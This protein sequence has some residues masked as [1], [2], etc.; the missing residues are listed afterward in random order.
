MNDPRRRRLSSPAKALLLTVA[1]VAGCVGADDPL[2]TSSGAVV[3]PMTFTPNADARVEQ[4]YGGSTF[5]TSSRLIVDGSPRTESYLRFQVSG[6]GW[7]VQRATLRLYAFDG[8]SSGPDVF[9][10]TSFWDENTLT[11]NNRPSPVGASVGRFR[12]VSK[13]NWVELDV[14]TAVTKEGVISFVL[15]PNSSDGMDFYSREGSR[16]PELIVVPMDPPTTPVDAGT[17]EDAGTA[18]DAGVLD[19]GTNADAGVTD[20]GSNADAGTQP[21]GTTFYVDATLGNDSNTGTSPSQAWRTTYRATQASLAPGDALRLARGGVYSGALKMAESGT[22]SKPILVA[23]YGSGAPPIITG[24]SSCLVV[25]GSYIVVEGVHAKD[26]TWA[27]VDLAGSHNRIEDL[28]ITG[29]AAGVH[30]RSGAIGNRILRSRLIDNNRMSVLTSGGDDDSGAFGLVIQGDHTEVAF[31]TIRGC[32]AFS[33]DYGRDGAAVE[34]YG[35]QNNHIHHN[36]AVDNDAF[37]ELGDPRSADNTFAYNVV[38]S[39]L[40]TSSFAVTRGASSGWGPVLRTRLYNNTVHLSGSS[41]QGFVCHGGCNPDI[42]IMRNNVIHAVWK[43]GYADG[44][45]D[46]DYDLFSGGQRQFTMG[47][48]SLVADPRFVD[49]AGGNLRLQSGSPAIDTGTTVSGYQSDLD[50][51]VVPGDGDGN[52]SAI[53]DRG[54]YEYQ[55]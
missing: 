17:S 4:K 48:H 8:T 1:C 19:A 31:N 28:D 44:P 55:R 21:T 46:G 32:D 22:S 42:L 36:V 25:S 11:W 23:A 50:G 18:V 45:F 33:Y 40:P 43:V 6:A 30:V 13:N 26:C 41:S 54:A 51:R 5:G 16:P 35:G 29:N 38:R 15:I 9:A 20:A 34:I 52:G 10:T 27:G 7:G 12:K 47:P 37:T 39:S 24:A 53:V 2:E 49:A 14:S 3:A